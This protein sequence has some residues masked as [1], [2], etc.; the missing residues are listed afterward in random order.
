MSLNW[1]EYFIKMAMLVSQKS[2]DQS[3]KVGCV[4]VGSGNAILSTGFN[5][6]PRKV[7][8][9]ETVVLQG[10]DY[11]VFYEEK[12]PILE[13]WERP[14]KYI[15]IE[16][17]ERNA[18]YNA[19]R[20]GIKLEGSR[21]YLN[22]EPIGICSDCCRGIIQSGIVEIIG[23][24]IAFGGFGKGNHYHTNYTKLMCDEASVKLT[25]IPWEPIE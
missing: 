19:A 18:C 15:F 14:T 4:I 6:F 10:G 9:E 24:D 3:T 12:R 17:A 7:A 13:R 23:P 21:L 5:G 8:E 25:T 22:Y 11:P 2:K 20:N 1:D 16:H